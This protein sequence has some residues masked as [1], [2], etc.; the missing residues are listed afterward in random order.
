MQQLTRNQEKERYLA[1][2]DLVQ[3]AWADDPTW[4]QRIRTDALERFLELP[5]PTTKDEDWKYT[6]VAPIVRAPW[7]FSVDAPVP[8]LD[9]SALEHACLGGDAWARLVFVDGAFAPEHSMVNH[10]GD[11]V[12]VMDLA[13]AALDWPELVGAHLG[14]Y[15]P[16]DVNAF[17]ALNAAYLHHGAVV[18]VQ[19]DVAIDMPIH[20]VFVSS[21]SSDDS[22]MV[23]QPRTLVVGGRGSRMGIVESYVSLGE[24][25]SLSNAVTEIA[26]EADAT[27]EHTTL[28]LE[29][30]NS[31]H[32]G[33]T[34]VHQGRASNYTSF[35]LAAGDALARNQLDVM[36]DEEGASCALDGLY[37]PD[38]TQHIDNH[39][40]IDHRMPHCTSRQLYKG[41]LSDRSRAV[42]NGKIVVRPGAQ[43]TD[44]QQQNR[45][46]LI[47]DEATVD[48]KPQLEI[49]ADDVKC[50]HG[51]T[52]G[53]LDEDAYFYL[54]SRGIPAARA[55]ALLTYGFASDVLERVQIEPLRA[56]L[57]HLLLE[58]LEP[59]AAAELIESDERI[60]SVEPIAEEPGL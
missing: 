10:A 12:Q 52:V 9:G 16:P 50:A 27:V 48:T 57:T 54:L 19:P 13:R 38:G 47:S 30:E 51:A 31:Y 41:V 46:L 49:F 5:F 23:S 43:K 45:N 3:A 36:L 25:R 32:I 53:Q 6:G 34:R 22:L 7:R 8:T 40:L 4:L 28:L 55:R 56:C 59:D 2:L 18:L 44:A 20:L 17:A 14:R 24:G 42:F 26:L 39:T 29:N 1:G 15:A 35:L 58:R 11:G 21:G 60:G 33:T 37:V